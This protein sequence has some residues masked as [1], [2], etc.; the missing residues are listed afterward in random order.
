MADRT[1]S[2]LSRLSRLSPAILALIG[3]LVLAGVG[4]GGYYAFRTYDF[5]EHDNDFC[6][7]CHLMQQPFELFA[8]SA[9]QG[10]G[11]KACHRPTLMGR[12]AMALTQLLESPEELSVHA[13]VPNEVCA[14]CHI[15]GDPE[16]W[17]LTAST[18][19]HSVHLE[20]ADPALAGLTCVECH[21]TS[22]HE[23]APTDRTCSQSGCH[24]D[25]IIR[26]GAM[27]QLTIHCA[28][29]HTFVAPIEQGT[30]GVLAPVGGS[31]LQPNADECLTCHIM[32]TLVEMP[33][34]DPHGGGCAACHNP[35]TQDEPADAAE[36]CAT[37]GCHE[38]PRAATA[39]HRG[40]ATDV[41]TDCVSCHAAHDFALDGAQCSACHTGVDGM[42]AAAAAPSSA[43]GQ[44]A[45]AHANHEI[46]ACT[47]CHTTTDAHGPTSLTTIADCR[48]CHHTEPIATRCVRCHTAADTPDEVYRR[49]QSVSFSVGAPDPSRVMEFP[50]P[51]HASLDC[52]S[53]HTQGLALAPPANLDCQACHAEHHTP[54]TTCAS[55]HEVA[56]E[57]A[58]PPTL[59]HVTCSGSGC[60]ADVPFETVPRTRAF[61]LGCHQ[62]LADH[63]PARTCSAC[64]TLPAPLPQR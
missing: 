41:L 58:H 8:E 39:F 43:Q 25:N 53:C 20:S 2:R 31:G 44:P 24:D 40:I 52:A 6:M 30:T 33:D 1:S 4:G 28:A 5:I 14:E 19:G 13:V 57:G 35:H 59:A 45:F 34:P 47:S 23:F 38:N 48:S 56:P 50:H 64:H 36:S 11:C 32:R 15:D 17:R 55:C 21:S 61:C 37:A 51:A 27:S 46:V 54:E 29:C 12:S 42:L 26:L 63:E 16:R 18:V 7:S 10:L 60:H 62:D 9:H 22:I 49:A 3:I